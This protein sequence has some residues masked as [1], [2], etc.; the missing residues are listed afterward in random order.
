MDSTGLSV[1]GARGSTLR[2]GG[3]GRAL[4]RAVEA[5]NMTPMWTVLSGP[6]AAR[7]TGLNA[8]VLGKTRPAS[9]ETSCQCFLRIRG[10]AYL[11][12]RVDDRSSTASTSMSCTRNSAYVTVLGSGRC[13]GIRR[14]SSRGDGV[15]AVQRT[16]AWSAQ[17]P[18]V[19]RPAKSKSSFAF[20]QMTVAATHQANTLTQA[21]LTRLPIFL[22]SEVKC[23]SGTI[24]K[25]SCSDRMT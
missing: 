12:G 8:R 3:E 14:Y 13:S 9:A 17:P 25:G 22:L 6:N 7:K 19:N 10:G 24:A 15:A 1:S 23:T 4:V 5:R 16:P 21:G 20:R 18:V 11:M 2:A